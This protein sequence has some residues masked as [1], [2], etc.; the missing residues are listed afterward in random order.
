M[1]HGNG[2]CDSILDTIGQTPLVRIRRLCP[3]PEVTILAKLEGFNPVGSVKERVAL[4]LIESAEAT[5][6]LTPDHTIV[7]SSSGNTG[8]GLAM[9]CAVRGYRL[10]ITM[11]QKVSIERRKILKALG[12]SIIYTSD[13]G[14][15]DEAWDIADEIC[16][17]DPEHYFRVRQYQ[18]TCN[19]QM[20]YTTTAE[21]IWRQTGGCVDALVV[22]L[23]TTGT[24]IG[25]GKRL[26]ELAPG[27]EVVAVEPE[28][29]HRQQGLRNIHTSRCPEIYLPEVVD[30]TL[31]CHDPEAFALAREL[32]LKEGIFCGISSGSAMWGAMEVARTMESGTVV[33]VFPDRGDKYLSTELFDADVSVSPEDVWNP[34]RWDN[35]A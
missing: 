35:H 28:P 6:Q 19:P 13:G 34:H 2:I 10:L 16:R 3:S 15:S 26:K 12:A 17:R 1:N 8:I 27:I 24:I 33:T 14:G 25:A 5:G 32:A 11:P 22:G 18:D 23:G 20:H 30:R 4:A 9:V 29:G 7:E 31:V 21:E